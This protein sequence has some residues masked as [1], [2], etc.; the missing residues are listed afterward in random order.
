M[1]TSAQSRKPTQFRG[2]GVPR[3]IA[4][5]RGLAQVLTASQLHMSCVSTAKLL[6]HGFFIV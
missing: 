4:S 3:G 1:H 5:N 2:P 6:T